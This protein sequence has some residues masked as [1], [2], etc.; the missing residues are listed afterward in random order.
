VLRVASSM[1]REK[2]IELH[3]WRSRW[4]WNT[5]RPRLQIVPDSALKYY[6]VLQSICG[7][8]MSSETLVG[9]RRVRS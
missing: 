1:H 2:T 8:F 3:S 9:F 6:P 4:N 7:Y 5:D